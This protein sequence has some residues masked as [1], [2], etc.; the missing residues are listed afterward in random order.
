MNPSPTKGCFLSKHVLS[1]MYTS[2]RYKP[3]GENELLY[4][5]CLII[6]AHKDENFYFLMIDFSSGK[7]CKNIPNVTL[8]VLIGRFI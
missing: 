5:N 1:I 3:T 2:G 6:L 8:P 4:V 7:M